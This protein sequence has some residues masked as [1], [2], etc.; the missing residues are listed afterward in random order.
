MC[1]RVAEI[2]GVSQRIGNH[3]LKVCDSWKDAG[4]NP[5]I[6]KDNLVRTRL[7]ALIGLVA[8]RSRALPCRGKGC[9]FESRQTRL[10]ACNRQDTAVYTA[11]ETNGRKSLPHFMKRRNNVNR[12]RDVH[13]EN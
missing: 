1:V 10:W 11:R 8:Q 5:A 9:G 7:L 13:L 2:D 12:K 4:S 3:A 6:R